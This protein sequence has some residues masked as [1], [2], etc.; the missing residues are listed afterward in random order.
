MKVMM[1]TLKIMTTRMMMVICQPKFSKGL[2]QLT[3]LGPPVGKGALLISLNA[4]KSGDNHRGK[5]RVNHNLNYFKICIKISMLKLRVTYTPH[6]RFENDTKAASIPIFE[7]ADLR[8][9]FL[10]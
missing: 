3:A 8:S 9:V 5:M 2:A 10:L 7:W 4:T 1:M 6:L